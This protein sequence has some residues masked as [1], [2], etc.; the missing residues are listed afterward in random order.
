[1]RDMVLSRIPVC[2]PILHMAVI[3]VVN[4]AYIRAK[5]CLSR[6]YC[7]GNHILLERVHIVVLWFEIFILVVLLKIIILDYFV[8]DKNLICL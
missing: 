7:I 2:L 5:T 3:A 1:M 8:S 6:P 4:T